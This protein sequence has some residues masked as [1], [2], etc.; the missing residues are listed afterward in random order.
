MSSISINAFFDPNKGEAAKFE[1]LGDSIAGTI[2]DV[3]MV[4]DQFNAGAQV[5]RLKLST[6]D[7]SVVDFY[8][9]SAGQ[10]EA[11]GAAVVKTGNSAIEVGGDFSITYTGDK[12]L[13]S[14]KSMKTYTATYEPPS[15][16]GV[17]QLADAE[18]SPF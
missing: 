17:A 1:N 6:D 4:D 16:M 18:A 13:R 14:G 5:L 7:G 15:P 10:K 3:E 12:A 9:R 8:C 2:L 11:T